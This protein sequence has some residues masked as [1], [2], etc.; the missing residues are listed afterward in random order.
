MRLRKGIDRASGR[1]PTLEPLTH[2]RLGT[3]GENGAELARISSIERLL[4]TSLAW[5]VHGLPAFTKLINGGNTLIM[6]RIDYVAIA[7]QF[8]NFDC[9]RPSFSF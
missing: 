3:V 2:R 8:G 1:L 9:G 5:V 6:L 7:P 4:A